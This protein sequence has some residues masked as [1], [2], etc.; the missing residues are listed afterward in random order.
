MCLCSTTLFS[1]DDEGQFEE[2]KYDFPVETTAFMATESFDEQ[3]W[4]ES[5]ILQSI[6]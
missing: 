5:G 3:N 2:M 1:N 6:L 4:R